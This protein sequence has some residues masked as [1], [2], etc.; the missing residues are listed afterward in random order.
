MEK[1]HYTQAEHQLIQTIAEVICKKFPNHVRTPKELIYT[2]YMAL[3]DAKAHY[4]TGRGA[5]FKTYASRCIYNAMLKELTQIHNVVSVPD[6]QR[7]NVNFVTINENQYSDEMGNEDTWEDNAWEWDL[8]ERD[9]DSK[10]C[11]QRAEM[12]DKLLEQLD[13]ED[14]ELVQRRY[15]FDEEPW[16]LKQLGEARGVSFQ[17]VHKKLHGIEQGLYDSLCSLCA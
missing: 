15:G 1:N 3:L 17:A 16:T 11:C 7:I 5:Q 14:R 9:W 2:G 10:Q 12:L 8:F 6:K 4:Q 13:P